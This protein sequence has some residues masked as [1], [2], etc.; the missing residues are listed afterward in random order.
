MFNALFLFF[1]RYWERRWKLPNGD[2]SGWIQRS[3]CQTA[4]TADNNRN[5]DAWV[6]QYLLLFVD[7]SG[8]SNTLTTQLV[9]VPIK[10]VM[11]LGAVG[12][13]A[14]SGTVVHQTGSKVTIFPFS[15]FEASLQ[16]RNHS[17]LLGKCL[18]FSSAFDQLVYGTELVDV[19]NNGVVFGNL[20]LPVYES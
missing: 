17:S 11:M 6:K 10:D 3:L 2:V 7:S 14:W 5:T 19:C 12:A 4:G 18:Q 13:Y 1:S 8:K 9:F 15:A 20:T 16:D